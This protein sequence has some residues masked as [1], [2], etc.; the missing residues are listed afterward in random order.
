MSDLPANH[1]S[2][3]LCLTGM[4]HGFTHLYGTALLPLYLLMQRDLKLDGVSKATSLVTVMMVAYFLPSYPLGVLADRTSRKKLLAYG[5]LINALAFVGLAFARNY[6]WAI[7]CVILAGIGGSS[8]HPAA[9]AMIARLFPFNTGRAL[10]LAGIGS[11]AGFFLGPL[12]TGWRAAT[13]EPELGAAAWRRPILEIGILGILAAGL[14]A[15]LASEEAV[16]VT[17]RKQTALSAGKLFPTPAL[18]FFFLLTSLLFSLRDFAGLAMASLSPLF[19]QNAEGYDTR[20]AGIA[21]SALFIGGVI[22]NPLLGS[23]SDGRRKLWITFVVGAGSLLIILFPHVPARWSIPCLLAFGFFFLASFPIV[24]A[25]LMQSVP[26]AVRGRVFGVWVMITGFVGG[27][28]AWVAG[29]LVKHMG[30]GAHERHNYFALYGAIGGLG[31]LA[32]AGLPCLHAIRKREHLD[33]NGSGIP[34][35]PTAAAGKASAE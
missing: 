6:P 16:V 30:D 2:R 11:G 7:A 24:E 28:A 35:S 5:L 19:L 27:L 18:W 4:L 29:L 13:L 9:T 22:S 21:V 31:L 3:T 32:L 12:Y 10:G 15:W 33:E 1:K 34:Q 26:D 17:G 8:Y 23:L 25:A 20:R 14:F